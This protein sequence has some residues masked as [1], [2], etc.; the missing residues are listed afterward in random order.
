MQNAVAGLFASLR[1]AAGVTV[2]YTQTSSGIEF[3]I[4]AV[5]GR[6]RFESEF[7]DGSVRSDS[8]FDFI[9]S[10]DDMALTPAR[11]DVIVWDDR[12]FEVMHPAGG[13][14]FEE[15][16]PYRQL[17]RVHTKEVYAG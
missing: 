17:Y 16:G 13:K 7:V 3:Q 2:E 10:A 1:G 12:R 15:I 11:G 5:P 8:A 9:M 6:T 4:T 14:V